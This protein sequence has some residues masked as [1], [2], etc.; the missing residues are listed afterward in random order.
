M[1]GP[2]P[3]GGPGKFAAES[4]LG[5]RQVLEGIG[6]DLPPGLV[7][8]RHPIDSE[9]QVIPALQRE[10]GDRPRLLDGLLTSVGDSAT[11]APAPLVK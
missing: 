1:A 6:P 9:K 8:M 5:S 2:R 7:P 4:R 11:I 10:Q 3:S